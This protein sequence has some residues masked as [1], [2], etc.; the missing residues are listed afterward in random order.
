MPRP[1]NGSHEPCSQNQLHRP[2]GHTVDRLGC[3]IAAEKL[4]SYQRDIAKGLSKAF[5]HEATEEHELDLDTAK[6]VVFS[7]HHKGARDGADDFQ[8]C[9]RA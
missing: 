3:D 5:D 9:E 7:D 8:R 6:L 2:S 4:D 1:A